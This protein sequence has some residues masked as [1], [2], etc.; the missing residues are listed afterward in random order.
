MKPNEGK[1]NKN[2]RVLYRKLR[3]QDRKLLWLGVLWDFW[4]VFP[5]LRGGFRRRR[6]CPADLSRQTFSG[7]ESLLAMAGQTQSNQYGAGFACIGFLRGLWSLINLGTAPKKARL[8][9]R[10]YG[11]KMIANRAEV[12]GVARSRWATVNAEGTNTF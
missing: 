2:D 9:P 11:L 1:K 10:S 8:T 6:P 5:Q 3:R 7:R 12:A 4:T